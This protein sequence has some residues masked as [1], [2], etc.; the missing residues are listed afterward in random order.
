MNNVKSRVF[1]IP[2]NLK[3]SHLVSFAS[4]RNLETREHNFLSQRKTAVTFY[5]YL[6]TL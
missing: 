6:H 5:K 2:S 4:T 1:N 3:E